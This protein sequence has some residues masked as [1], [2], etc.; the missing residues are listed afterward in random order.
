MG[1]IAQSGYFL[2]QDVYISDSDY[3]GMDPFQGLCLCKLQGKTQSNT[4]MHDSHRD[5]KVCRWNHSQVEPAVI[6]FWGLSVPGWQSS[7][8]PSRH[9]ALYPHVL[10]TFILQ[11]TT[12]SVRLVSC[13]TRELVGWVSRACITHRQ[14]N[15]FIYYFIVAVLHPSCRCHHAVVL[16][17]WRWDTSVSKDLNR[18]KPLFPES[19][20]W[21]LI[22]ITVMQF[23]FQNR[24]ESFQLFLGAK[25]CTTIFTRLWIK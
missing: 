2:C 22:R 9:L 13:E 11:V 25:R 5:H 21:T 6:L 12:S 24:I 23:C 17:T 8:F 10:M 20:D 19:C 18:L 14:N 7:A 1:C 4:K 3:S 16:G 15:N